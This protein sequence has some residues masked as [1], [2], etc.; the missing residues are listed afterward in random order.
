MSIILRPATRDDLKTIWQMQVE[1]FRGLLE[2]YQDYELSPAAESIDKTIARFEQPETVYY[3]ISAEGTDVG[4]IRIVDGHDGTRKRISPLWI[5]P[6]YRNRGYAQAAIL[7]AEAI[8]GA[9]NWE[10]ETILQEKGN[11]HLYEKLGYRR[12][13]RTDRINDKMD[14]VYYEKD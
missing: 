10:L 4:V 9:D 12:T 3:F 11:C 7:A 6:E 8:H 13:G 14:I 2:V 1:A 5:M